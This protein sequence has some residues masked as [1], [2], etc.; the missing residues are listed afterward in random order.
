MLR[1]HTCLFPA[2]WHWTGPLIIW[3]LENEGLRCNNSDLPS[4][5]GS[6]FSSNGPNSSCEVKATQLC[7][8]HCDPMDCSMS[9]S[10]VHGINSPG[11]NTGVVAIPFSRGSFQ[12][13]DGTQVS[14]IAGGL[15]TI[16]VT[17]E[18]PNSSYGAISSLLISH[19][20]VLSFGSKEGRKWSRVD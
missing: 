12:P 11:Q 13:R 18:A 2:I 5:S 1:P 17:R 14:H 9:G 6:P 20:N 7:P 3:N 10:S 8:T 15:F 19:H 16:W 4:N